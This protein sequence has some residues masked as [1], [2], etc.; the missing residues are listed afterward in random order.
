MI[1]EPLS[2]EYPSPCP[3][4]MVRKFRISVCGRVII[5]HL[6]PKQELVF[7][8]RATTFAIASVRP[9]RTRCVHRL[10]PSMV[11]PRAYTVLAFIYWP[12]I[13]KFVWSWFSRKKCSGFGE[14][15]GF[16]YFRDATAIAVYHRALE[17]QRSR[18]HHPNLDLAY[19]RSMILCER[20]YSIFGFYPSRRVSSRSLCEG[21]AFIS[22][23]AAS[24]VAT[25]IGSDARRHKNFLRG[26]LLLM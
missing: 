26:M 13:S 10:A 18:L 24:F 15:F 2:Y 19:E 20:I 3:V 21:F 25:M 1:R 17:R 9:S 23:V 14:E 11:V 6:S 16:R 4:N 8:S 7:D 5:S 22:P 12:R